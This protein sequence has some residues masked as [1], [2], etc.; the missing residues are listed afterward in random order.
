MGLLKATGSTIETAMPSAL[1]EMAV[2]IFLHQV[3]DHRVLGTRPLR[4]RPQKRLRILDAVTGRYEEGVG[5]HVVDEDEVPL[6]RVREVAARPALPAS[7]TPRLLRRVAA[8]P[9]EQQP[10]RSQRTARKKLLA[11]LACSPRAPLP[12]IARSLIRPPLSRSSLHYHATPARHC[13]TTPYALVKRVSV[14]KGPRYVSPLW[15]HQRPILAV[16]PP[17]T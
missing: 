8:A 10:G 11:A 12:R 17:S 16:V 1:P 14:R 3:L 5:G 15:S 2:F 4:R 7:T 9:G 6:R 13:H